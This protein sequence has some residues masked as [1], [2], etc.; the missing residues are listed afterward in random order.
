M[1]LAAEIEA[2]VDGLATVTGLNAEKVTDRDWLKQQNASFVFVAP[3]GSGEQA[4]IARSS[5]AQ[6]HRIPCELWLK[7]TGDV[8]RLYADAQALTDAILAWLRTQTTVNINPG[9][10]VTYTAQDIKTETN[11]LTHRLV[12]ITVPVQLLNL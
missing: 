2:L 4:L 12:T 9:E 11:E 7:N 8:Q 10:P 1:T 6:T 5:Y 3:S